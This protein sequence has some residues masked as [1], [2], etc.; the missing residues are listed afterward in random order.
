MPPKKSVAK[1]RRAFPIV[2]VGASA[3]GLEAFQRLLKAL[4]ANS[5]MAFAWFNWQRG[6]RGHPIMQRISWDDERDAGQ[7][8][9]L[10]ATPPKVRGPVRRSNAAPTEL[11][12]L[13]ACVET[14][15]RT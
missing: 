12:C 10:T 6:Y 2:G 13:R 9:C 4:P 8:S 15:G 14:D 7:S 1:F 5:G 11:M 3:G